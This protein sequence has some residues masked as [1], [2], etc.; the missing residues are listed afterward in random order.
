MVSEEW[1]GFKG[2]FETVL[3]R[4]PNADIYIENKKLKLEWADSA[5]KK[6]DIFTGRQGELKTSLEGVPDVYN[7]KYIQLPKI[8][9]YLCYLVDWIYTSIV[10]LLSVSWGVGLIIFA[11]L[12]RF[13][14]FPILN[15][16]KKA[17]HVV[18]LHRSELQPL[19]AEIKKTLKGEKAHKELMKTYKD[20]KITPYYTLKPLLFT[21][22]GLPILIA[23]FNML[24]EIPYFQTASFLWFDSLAY[25]DNF[26]TLPISLPFF[27][28][29]LNLLPFFMTAVTIIASMFLKGE[30][31]SAA[32]LKRQKIN[33]YLMAFVFFL[34]FYNFP[35]G[36]VFYWTIASALA[37]FASH[38]EPIKKLKLWFVRGL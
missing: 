6:I 9:R 30:D 25:P 21:L 12:I 3:I 8:I 16:T 37:I 10:E 29:R 2:R 19:H 31:T 33:L 26:A 27:G 15:L 35:S 13:L 7:L 4:A 38:F 24:G 5:E 22:L 11:V 20:R 17:Q 34:L 28:N 1:V 36:M 23:I 18:N 14:M 32:D